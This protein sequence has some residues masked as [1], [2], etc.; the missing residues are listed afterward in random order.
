MGVES[1]VVDGLS[2]PPVVL[3]PGGVGIEEIRRVPGWEGVR[4]GYREG[5]RKGKGGE[6]D[7]DGEEEE[8]GEDGAK[9]PRAP[10][11]KYRHYSP[12]A[13]VVLA[14]AG[15]GWEVVERRLGDAVKGG[16]GKKV[17]VLR[18]KTWEPLQGKEV[19][20]GT[21]EVNGVSLHLPDDIKDSE[22][23]Q[24]HGMKHLNAQIDNIEYEVWDLCIG[25]QVADVAKGLFSALREM[26]LRGVS[27]I[28]VE[29][30]EDQGEMGAA[31]MNRL[32][33]A[34]GERIGRDS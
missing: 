24:P 5:D 17:G 11:M 6:N 10:G 3:R 25:T 23:V 31:V 1:T 33:K 12:A 19:A 4:V 2:D 7:G 16:E 14:E 13:R 28:F 32:R 34:A 27:V 9:G 22:I 18:T 15:V 26:D 29:G 21:L 20:N 8:R 30:I